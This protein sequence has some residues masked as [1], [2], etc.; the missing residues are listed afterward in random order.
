MVAKHWC[1]MYI[2]LFAIEFQLKEWQKKGWKQQREKK[3]CWNI[4]IFN[5]FLSERAKYI[6]L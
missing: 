6:C 1:K 4:I 2:V 3:H 5:K